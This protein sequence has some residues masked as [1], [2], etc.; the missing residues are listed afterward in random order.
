MNT[1]VLSYLSHTARN[2]LL[3]MLSDSWTACLNRACRR[4][5]LDEQGQDWLIV[6]ALEFAFS[7][8]PLLGKA[9]QKLNPPL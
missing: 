6:T 9:K 8:A 3:Q 2:S 7:R 5:T 4:S 1:V